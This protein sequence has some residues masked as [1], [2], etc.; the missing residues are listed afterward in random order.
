MKMT[1]MTTDV[2]KNE[3]FSTVLYI[4]RQIFPVTQG[5]IGPGDDSIVSKKDAD[6]LEKFLYKKDEE[7]L[8]ILDQGL[9][10]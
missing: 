5:E 2:R 9:F 7:K 10:S 6:G 1:L 8:G 4:L 3:R